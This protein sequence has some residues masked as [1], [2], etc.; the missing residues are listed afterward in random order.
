MIGTPMKTEI[1]KS[2][3]LFHDI[4]LRIV[5]LLN[6]ILVALPLSGCWFLYYNHQISLLES[7]MRSVAI[8]MLFAL[9][10]AFFGRV[11]DAFLVSIKRISEL[12]FSQL[13]G[14]VMADAVM[15]VALWLM[16]ASF[17]NMLPAL[18]ALICQL[19]LSFFWC[20]YGH[21]WYYSHYPAQ[22]T[23]I[24]CGNAYD[25]H[26]IL[27]QYGLG[28][29]F[30]VQVTC[31]AE[32]CLNGGF[33]MLENMEAV[34]LCGIHSHERNQILK[35]CISGG[36]CAY[37]IPRLGDII[38]SGSKSMHMFHRPVMRVGSYRPT[39]EYLLC[40]RLFDIIASALAILVASPVMLVV[41][42]A[43]KANDGGPAFYRQTRLTRNGREFQ[44]LKFRS[45][46]V[47]AEKDGVAR[48]S[49]GGNDSRITPV[50]HVIRACR[51]D[52]LP[53]LINILLG[54]MSVVG[55]RP[56]RPEI[57][58]QYE[59]QMTE[60]SLRL[61]AKAGLTGYAQVYGKYNTD[62]YDKLQM[63]LM[64]IAKPSFVEDLKIIF[65]TIKILFAPESTEGVAEGQ[66][67]A[68]GEANTEPEADAHKDKNIA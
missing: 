23:A 6:V 57:A 1:R 39:P 12:F 37:V 10:Y 63:D 44:I 41:A 62:P 29:K 32:E 25:M 38:M 7:P 15:F 64:Y 26:E 46:R 30:D 56:E 54:D 34:F 20:K 27:S 16:S 13:L 59:Q 48:L 55:P 31:T 18:T 49:T 58:R 5:K 50:G 47:D 33:R 66:T 36:I 60:F 65:A 9:L 8:V 14:I 61:Q 45:M 35:H 43:I 3:Q 67:T 17:P 42:I 4:Q 22:R 2:E 40:K 52:E 24:V 28:K 19:A 51:L 68:L 11:Y 53:Q 21:I